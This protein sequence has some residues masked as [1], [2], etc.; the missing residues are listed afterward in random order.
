MH[1][2]VENQVIC[3][4]VVESYKTRRLEKVCDET[5]TSIINAQCR[6]YLI[7]FPNYYTT[8][9]EECGPRASRLLAIKLLILQRFIP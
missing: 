1:S 6:R 8:K 2:N 4:L 7:G 9:V 5:R 3:I